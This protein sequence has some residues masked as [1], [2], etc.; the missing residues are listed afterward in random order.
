M[1]ESLSQLPKLARLIQALAWV[2]PGLPRFAAGEAA[3]PDVEQRGLQTSA[4]MQSRTEADPTRLAWEAPS[5]SDPGIRTPLPET[6][7][8][9]LRRWAPGRLGQEWR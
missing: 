3:G 6:P 9:Q 4:A 1:E 2:Q 5:G 7:D 8:G